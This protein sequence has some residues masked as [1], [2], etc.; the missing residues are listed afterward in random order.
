MSATKPK[1]NGLLCLL[2][3]IFIP[4]II[5][6]SVPALLNGQVVPVEYQ[7]FIA[8]LVGFGG[9][10]LVVVFIRGIIKLIKYNAS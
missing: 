7:G 5:M 8:S 3:E 9:I 6:V 2:F 10:I 4:I 1:L